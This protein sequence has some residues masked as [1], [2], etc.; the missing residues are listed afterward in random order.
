MIVHINYVSIQPPQPTVHNTRRMHACQSRFATW[1]G[2]QRRLPRSSA[3]SRCP[4]QPEWPMHDPGNSV[5]RNQRVPQ[6]TFANDFNDK[7]CE[8]WDKRGRLIPVNGPGDS[9]WTRGL[10]LLL[11]VCERSAQMRQLAWAHLRDFGRHGCKLGVLHD[12]FPSAVFCGSGSNN[13]WGINPHTCS[14]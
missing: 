14:E 2:P 1:L 3:G 7:E 4:Q 6:I 13:Q 11:D 12:C 10:L 9:E 8:L 5:K